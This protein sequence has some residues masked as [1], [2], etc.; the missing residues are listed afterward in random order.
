MVVTIEQRF[1]AV[2]GTSF[3]V[4]TDIAFIVVGITSAATGDSPSVITGDS[5]SAATKDSPST[6]TGDSPFAA[7]GDSPSIT[8]DTAFVVEV[9]ASVVVGSSFATIVEDITFAVGGTTIRKVTM[10]A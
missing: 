2:I 3:E 10:A 1:E 6:V 8:E 9:T 7:T 5:P 4:A